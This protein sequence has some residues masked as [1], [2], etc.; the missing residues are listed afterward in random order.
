MKDDKEAIEQFFD[1]IDYLE[2]KVK[3]NMDRN[4][5]QERQNDNYPPSN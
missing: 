2:N 1:F 3:S 4:T 5:G